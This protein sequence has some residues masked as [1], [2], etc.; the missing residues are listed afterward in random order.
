MLC[1]AFKDAWP[2][3]KG[4]TQTQPGWAWPRSTD[5]TSQDKGHASVFLCNHTHWAGWLNN[6]LAP[7]TIL[8]RATW[9][10]KSCGLEPGRQI[11]ALVWWRQAECFIVQVEKGKLNTESQ[12]KELRFGRAHQEVTVRTS[13][14]R[15]TSCLARESEGER[16]FSLK[17]SQR[18]C[19]ASG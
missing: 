8:S 9:I 18:A 3:I 2:G 15:G 4:L 11:E 1:S 17:I 7:A 19:S 5:S 10:S 16:S 14:G 13:P 12:V 6:K